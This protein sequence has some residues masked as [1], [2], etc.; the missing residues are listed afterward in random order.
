METLYSWV[1]EQSEPLLALIA[2]FAVGCIVG[3]LDLLI[4]RD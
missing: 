1:M 2:L 3:L 4:S